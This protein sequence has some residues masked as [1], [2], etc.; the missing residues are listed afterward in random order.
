MIRHLNKLATEFQ[1]SQRGH[2]VRA[3]RAYHRAAASDADRLLVQLQRLANA[4]ND[5][6]RHA[7][8]DPGR[9]GR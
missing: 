2:T 5:R 4:G 3:Q 9:V 1:R 8:C 6:A 7:R